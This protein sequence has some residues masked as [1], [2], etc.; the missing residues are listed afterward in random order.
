MKRIVKVLLL[1]D[2]KTRIE[3]FKKR[4]RENDDIH[5][6]VCYVDTAKD[7]I[8]ALQE[9]EFCLFLADHDLGGEVYVDVNNTNT[10]SEVARWI[11]DN[12]D[13]YKPMPVIV[14]SLNTSAAEYMVGLIPNC[15][16]IPFLWSAEK[17]GR[18]NF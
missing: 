8:S 17:F 6:D 11:R 16:H 4:F 10:G 3:Y 13:K 18:I 5:F 1:E 12:P 14:H 7:C 2:D 15:C 9:Q